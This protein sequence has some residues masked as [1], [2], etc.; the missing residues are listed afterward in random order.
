MG[1]DNHA[2]HS[3]GGR[4]SEVQD[5]QPR[6]EGPPRP[7]QRVH[8]PEPLGH[9][10]NPLKP[11]KEYVKNLAKSST[12][13]SSHDFSLRDIVLN[14]FN[15]FFSAIFGL[16]NVLFEA[17]DIVIWLF[18]GL[19]K[20]VQCQSYQCPQFLER[21]KRQEARNSARRRYEVRKR[22]RQMMMNSFEDTYRMEEEIADEIL[23]DCD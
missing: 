18:Q 10:Y 9:F 17:L 11:E 8:I 7:A 21:L 2:H 1:S 6:R 14:I 12:P 16:R 3:F 13:K 22:M 23:R 15:F 19:F 20:I 4:P 5:S